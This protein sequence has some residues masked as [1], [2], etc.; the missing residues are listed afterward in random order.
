MKRTHHNSNSMDLGAMQTIKTKYNFNTTKS[1]T[2][3]KSM[4]RNPNKSINLNNNDKNIFRNS[5]VTNL[6]T[7]N[8]FNS[9]YEIY[10]ESNYERPLAFDEFKE[11]I[12]QMITQ[13][14]LDSADNKGLQKLNLENLSVEEKL[15][16]KETLNAYTKFKNQSKDAEI[17]VNME[18]RDY[19]NP[20]DS[21]L[22]IKKNK[23]ISGQI[24]FDFYD[25]TRQIYNKE[26]DKIN[27]ITYNQ[28]HMPKK[29]R[30]TN[31]VGNKNISPISDQTI[32]TKKKESLI[33]PSIIPV[34]K[35]KFSELY[36]SYVYCTKNFPESREQFTLT[37]DLFDVVMFGGMSSNKSTTVWTLDPGMYNLF[38]KFI[39]L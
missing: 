39:I 27:E 24:T 19:Q 13:Y 33:L 37:Y 32:T 9:L 28:E 5:H 3:Q 14:K 35:N 20:Y 18:D 22:I 8:P 25:R 17:R 4:Y 16:I 15:K 2:I 12:S 23:E 7:I 31:L 11:K 6:S 30:V 1:P 36:G 26:I 10:N 38:D 21:A 29:I 34:G